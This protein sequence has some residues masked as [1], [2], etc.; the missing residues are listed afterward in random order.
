MALLDV[1][2]SAPPQVIIPQVTAVQTVD[3]VVVYKQRRLLELWSQEQL[4]RQYRVA[5]GSNAVGAKQREGDRR[6]PEGRYT[7]DWRNRTDSL[8]HFSIHIS[9]PNDSEQQQAS[10]QGFSPGG[11]IMIHGQPNW[12]AGFAPVYRPYDWTL[13]CIAVN[14][15]AME[16][17]LQLVYDG[18]P[19]DIYP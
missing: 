11:L 18:T 9:Y 13:G 6:T 7:L 19:I 3:R 15:E 16:E 14:N 2:A 4:V 12:L 1:T 10:Q 5:L 17:I 8:Y